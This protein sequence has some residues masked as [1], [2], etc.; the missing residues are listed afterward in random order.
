MINN[1][2][3]LLYLLKPKQHFIS[4]A[5]KSPK[6]NTTKCT[7]HLDIWNFVGVEYVEFSTVNGNVGRSLKRR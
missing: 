7:F 5:L 6:T 3:F 4:V 1:K 2:H